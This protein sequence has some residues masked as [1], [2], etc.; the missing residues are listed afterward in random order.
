LIERC[1]R[2]EKPLPPPSTKEQFLAQLS[3]ALERSDIAALERL[4]SLHYS[5]PKPAK[6]IRELVEKHISDPGLAKAILFDLGAD[7]Q[8]Q[9]TLIAQMVGYLR[10]ELEK[11]KKHGASASEIRNREEAI[12]ELLLSKGECAGLSALWA[13]AKRLSDETGASQEKKAGDKTGLARDDEAFFKRSQRLLVL[14]HPSTLSPAEA[15]DVERFISLV[16]TLQLP[17]WLWAALGAESQLNLSKAMENT[18]GARLVQEYSHEKLRWTK[19]MLRARLPRFIHPRLMIFIGS[20]NDTG[21]HQMAIYQSGESKVHGAGNTNFYNPNSREGPVTIHSLDQLVDAVWDGA[22]LYEGRPMAGFNPIRDAFRDL[23]ITIFRLPSDPTSTYPSDAELSVTTD[24][25]VRLITAQPFLLSEKALKEIR[26][27][28]SLTNSLSKKQIGEI[29]AMSEDL[30]E[31]VQKQLWNIPAYKYYTGPIPERPSPKTPELL[32]TPIESK[33]EPARPFDAKSLLKIVQAMPEE[34]MCHFLY[35]AAFESRLNL[36]DDIQVQEVIESRALKPSAQAALFNTPRFMLYLAKQTESPLMDTASFI[37][38]LE[39]MQPHMPPP[40][41]SSSS[42][43]SA[44]SSAATASTGTSSDAVSRLDMYT[45]SLIFS[46]IGFQNL[47][48]SLNKDQVEEILKTVLDPTLRAMLLRRPRFKFVAGIPESPG[49]KSMLPTLSQLRKMIGNHTKA[50]DAMPP[51]YFSFLDGVARWHVYR[52]LDMAKG[53]D[54]FEALSYQE[55]WAS[56]LNQPNMLARYVVGSRHWMLF[57]EGRD[58][59][60]QAEYLAKLRAV[61]GIYLFK[62]PKLSPQNIPLVCGH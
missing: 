18:K 5:F 38:L 26:G 54:R 2:K 51:S 15:S 13:Y 47:I 11:A 35:S 21:G 4:S 29:H 24:E 30:P 50:G 14:R 19:E 23:S 62:E 20:Q 45:I 8:D 42:S 1:D 57:P 59:Q 56:G 28:Y 27:M 53:A 22:N 3:K 43:S 46:S 60:I 40:S 32:S 55:S 37:Q 12:R 49:P 33:S 41:S 7:H 61:R 6:D 44:A 25:F 36:M 31:A 9:T 16:R 34:L 52:A 58:C 39:L 17:R 48:D 10:F